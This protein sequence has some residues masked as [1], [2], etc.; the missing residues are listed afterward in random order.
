MQILMILTSHDK[1][2]DTG[3]K[4]GYWLEEFAAPYYAFLDAGAEITLASPAGGKPPLD[5]QSDVP[6]AQTEATERF[7]KDDAA[8]HAL[9][10]TTQL[11][12]INAD[13]FDA[14]FFPGGH[15]P[16]WDLAE[17][18]DSQ[19]IIEKSV[20]ADR[21]LAAVCHAPAVF[22]HTKR[23]DGKPL[24]SGR[25]VTGFTNTEEEGVG[26]TE[27]VPFLIEDMLIANG[28]LYEK[29]LDW[30]SYVVV[31]GKLVTG[32]NPASSAAAAKAL[33]KLLKHP[34]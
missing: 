30:G 33:L 28:G 3:K 14:I 20:A 24:V 18:A 7:K 5:P 4:T 29:G 13:G 17:N 9:A 27:I 1:L 26:L 11:T 25:R 2:G 15:G 19:R 8:Q 22:K 32:Q 16:V 23:A 34:V 10:S 12:E 6:D 21:P 31:D